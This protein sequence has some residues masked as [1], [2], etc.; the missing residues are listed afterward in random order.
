MRA[1]CEAVFA[2]F[3]EI[4]R[5]FSVY[6]EESPVSRYRRGERSEQDFSP[7]ERYVWEQCQKVKA[8]SEGYFDAFYD[9]QYDPTGIVKGYAIRRGAE[10]LRV[11]GYRQYMIEIAGDGEVG[12]KNGGRAWRVGIANP[13]VKGEII[14]IVQLKDCGIA[15]SGL[16]EHPDHIINPH[17]HR[18]A[19]TLA[20]MS[21][22]ARDAE[23]ADGL[24]TAALAM[25][26]EGIEYLE[27]H[28]YAAYAVTDDKRGIATKELA[29]Y[30]V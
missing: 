24:A 1:D 3:D 14:K 30:A 4:D 25:G 20:S 8:E 12:E 10:L 7:E 21:V 19:R 26:M 9:G 27:K 2:L 23:E 18:P 16:A 29:K 6:R 5:T 22:I 17:T 11:K 28:G 13:F 15:T